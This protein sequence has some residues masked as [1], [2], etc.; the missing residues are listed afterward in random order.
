MDSQPV[1]DPNPETLCPFDAADSGGQIRA[2]KPSVGGF[3]SEPPH[4]RQAQVDG[5][6]CKVLLFEEKP[7]AKDDSPVKGQTRF[8]TVPPDE[9]VD[10]MTVGF[11]RTGRCERVE[12]CVLRLLQVGQPKYCFGPTAFQWVPTWHTGGLL[13]RSQYGCS[14]GADVPEAGFSGAS[15]TTS[16]V[17]RLYGQVNL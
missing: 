7:V 8:G 11:L 6:G 4:R 3:I 2:Q 14:V 9:F 17:C 5:G 12:N 15:R 10:G 16:T 1:A 13:C